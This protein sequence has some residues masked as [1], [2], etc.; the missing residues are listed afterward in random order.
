[1]QICKD[2]DTLFICLSGI[3]ILQKEISIIEIRGN[4]LIL[5]L[6]FAL[7]TTYLHTDFQF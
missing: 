5:F 6:S 7:F 2:N 1:M 4:R 3:V